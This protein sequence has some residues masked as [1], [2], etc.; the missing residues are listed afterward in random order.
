M[1]QL[2]FTLGDRRSRRDYSSSP[3]PSPPPRRKPKR[4]KSL[5]QQAMGAMGAL[6][7][8]NALSG[9]KDS[10]SHRRHQSEDRGTRR[11]RRHRDDS[12]SSSRSRSRDRDGRD[13]K[14]RGPGGMGGMDQHQ[15]AQAVKAALTAGAAEAYRAR[16]E[17]GG[18]TGEKGKRIITAALASGGA[19]SAIDR[20]S[21]SNKHSK[22]HVIESALAG[23]ATNRA[24]NGPRDGSRDGKGGFSKSGAAKGVATTGALALAGKEIYDHLKS[25]SK[26]RGRDRSSSR[27]SDD[28]DRDPRGGRR[29]GTKKRSKSLSD[30]I[31]KG[32]AA[33]GLDDGADSDKDKR[34]DR[35]RRHGRGGG[36]RERS[37]RYDDPYDS[38]SYSHY[39][40]EIDYRPRRRGGHGGGDGNSRDVGR[41]LQA[42]PADH[43]PSTALSKYEGGGG[44]R[45]VAHYHPPYSY[46]STSTPYTDNESDLGSSSEEENTRKKMV[47]GQLLTTGMATIATVHAGYQIVG[48][49]KKRKER[50]AAVREGDLDPELARR[51]RW[52]NNAKDVASIGVAAVSLHGAV[53]EWKDANKKRTECQK[54]KETARERAMRRASVRS[55]SVDGGDIQRWREGTYRY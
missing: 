35:H 37:S 41:F 52:K 36:H 38:D 26:S 40:S 43:N 20:H 18:W 44:E 9:D 4:R 6:G 7:L 27:S 55:K 15:I 45:A 11:R 2:T 13:G 34:D 50:L 10:S 30:Y 8:G 1:N 22:R 28:D 12:S 29:G 16:K 21:D 33:V 49:M 39:D 23:L 51:E 32:L 5:T 3:S 53:D 14:V 19:D 24:V 42:P 17:P 48:S 47:R 25:R 46:N 54:F 31:S